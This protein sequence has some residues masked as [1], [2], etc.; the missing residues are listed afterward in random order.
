MMIEVKFYRASCKLEWGTRSMIRYCPPFDRGC[1]P[2]LPLDLYIHNSS[3]HSGHGC[4][5]NR[6]PTSA[7]P[8]T[9]TRPISRLDHARDKQVRLANSASTISNYDTLFK[10]SAVLL[11]VQA[12]S[13]IYRSKVSERILS[14]FHHAMIY[15]PDQRNANMTQD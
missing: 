15:E 6:R 8:F 3:G 14:F 11:P 12:S 2:L 4:D 13:C 5:L 1:P 7:P 10:V 9:T